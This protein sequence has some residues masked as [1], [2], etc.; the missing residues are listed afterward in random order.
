MTEAFDRLSQE[1]VEAW[2]LYRR[3]CTRFT[4]DFHAVPVLLGRVIEDRDMDEAIDLTER[5][6]MIYDAVNPPPKKRD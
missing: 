6:A 3:I 5:L 2:G 1:N 4:F